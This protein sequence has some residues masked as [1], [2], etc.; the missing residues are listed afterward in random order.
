MT[1]CLKILNSEKGLKIR[2]IIK[3]HNFISQPKYMLWVLKRTVSMRQNFTV[4]QR[5]SNG[6]FSG[7]LSFFKVPEGVQ[8]FLG[9]RG[10][11]LISIETYRGSGPPYPP[12]DLHTLYMPVNNVLG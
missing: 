11:M 3:N 1:D 5:G 8:L 10:G 12:L 9:G 2:Y 7:K 4:L 6:L